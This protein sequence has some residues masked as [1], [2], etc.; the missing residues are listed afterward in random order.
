MT[1]PTPEPPPVVLPPRTP[2]QWV[3]TVVTSVLVLVPMVAWIWFVVAAGATDHSKAVPADMNDQVKL[4][5]VASGTA[6]SVI[7]G[8]FLGISNALGQLSIQGR[9]ATS[10]GWWARLRTGVRTPRLSTSAIA[11]IVY[12][13]GIIIAV[14]I[15]I[16][17]KNK[18]YSVDVI[19]T[20]LATLVGFGLGALKAATTKPA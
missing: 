7:A 19:Q 14:G 1:T 10:G 8:S 11:T 13:L 18:D 17:D 20:S 12:F 15:W 4:V 6:L 3:I 5:G 2:N 16:F 9:D